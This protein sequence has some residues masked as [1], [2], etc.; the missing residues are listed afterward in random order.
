M[1]AR[2]K[3]PTIAVLLLTAAL[4][5]AVPAGAHAQV[6]TGAGCLT[7]A[8]AERVRA[9]LERTDQVLVRAAGHLSDCESVR[10]RSLLREG[11]KIQADAWARFRD[12]GESP[13]EHRSNQARAVRLTRRAR[14]LAVKAIEACQVD[15]RAH[16]SVTSMLHSTRELAAEAEETVRLSGS[17]DARRLL[18]A[19]VRQLEH[20]MDAHRSRE[21]R[22]AITLG[23]AA[24]RLIQR[25][26][27]RAQMDAGSWGAERAERALDRTDQIIQ[28]MEGRIG[29][30]DRRIEAFM[31]RARAEQEQARSL[32]RE[33][34]YE[35]AVRLTNSARRS[36]LDAIW[37]VQRTP[38]A[39]RVARALEV[40]ERVLQ[41]T[42][43]EILRSGLPEALKLLEAAEGH[44]ESAHAFLA[45]DDVVKAAQAARTADSLLRRAAESA[46]R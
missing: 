14:D 42:G 36:V 13:E 39:D 43:P 26:A 30:G 22:R 5:A 16:Q 17:P 18:D 15:F 37:E 9:E 4:T 44:M 10:G 34:R 3:R 2:M 6:H 38:D 19:G 33:G 11:R 8:D 1:K 27:Q 35:P 32:Y 41:E 45:Q 24:R 31:N 21:P 20:A 29:R 7:Q 46:G 28:E 40:L 12:R 25:A 23:A